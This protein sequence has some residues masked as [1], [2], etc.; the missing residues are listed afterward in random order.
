MALLFLLLFH[1][2]IVCLFSN[3]YHCKPNKFTDMTASQISAQ[4]YFIKSILIKVNMTH[5]ENKKKYEINKC[6]KGKILKEI[7]KIRLNAIVWTF[8]FLPF[9]NALDLILLMERKVN[10]LF[11]LSICNEWISNLFNVAIGVNGQKQIS[12]CSMQIILS[13]HPL[14]SFRTPDNTYAIQVHE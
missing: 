1:Y 5:S 2:K 12:S 10:Y 11:K 3:R 13:V 8:I 7:L 14:V 4:S 9:V 6:C